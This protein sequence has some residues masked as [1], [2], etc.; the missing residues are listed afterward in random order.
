ML[1]RNFDAV[2]L[3]RMGNV[4]TEISKKHKEQNKNMINNFFR[5]FYTQIKKGRHKA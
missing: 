4:V 5:G 2:L 1:N 3:K